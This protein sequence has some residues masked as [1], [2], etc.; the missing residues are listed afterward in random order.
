MI[1][2]QRKNIFLFEHCFLRQSFF[3]FLVMWNRGRLFGYV[4]EQSSSKSLWN[5]YSLRFHELS[6][7]E[8]STRFRIDS[9]KWD[10]IRKHRIIPAN[11]KL[12]TKLCAIFLIFGMISQY[13]FEMAPSSSFQKLFHFIANAQNFYSDSCIKQCCTPETK[14]CFSSFLERFRAMK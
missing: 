9:E 3:D 2:F 7:V 11:P 10:V 5:C 4:K 1:E 8:I 14:R 13:L 12:N 6:G